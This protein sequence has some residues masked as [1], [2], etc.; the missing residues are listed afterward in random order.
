MSEMNVFVEVL[1]TKFRINIH[2]GETYEALSR[3]LRLSY[4]QTTWI[5]MRVGGTNKGLAHQSP[6]FRRSIV[7]EVSWGGSYARRSFI[8]PLD[9]RW[10][11]TLTAESPS[12]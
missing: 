10:L 11:R 7:M 1:F 9:S 6:F 3:K 5:K 8:A 2:T 4:K 12:Y